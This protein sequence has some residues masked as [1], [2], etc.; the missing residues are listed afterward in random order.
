[1][2]YTINLQVGELSE[3][4]VVNIERGD[5][6]SGF[7]MTAKP[8]VTEASFGRET[9]AQRYN[10]FSLITPY[11]YD[12]KIKKTHETFFFAC[13][14]AVQAVTWYKKQRA[15][16]GVGCAAVKVDSRRRVITIYVPIVATVEESL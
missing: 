3:T 13:D 15:T 1:M 11:D 6:W 8:F 4:A 10:T 16:F 12:V 5:G 7:T 9:I 2:R 14:N